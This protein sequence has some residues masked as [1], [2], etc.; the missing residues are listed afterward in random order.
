MGLRA[1]APRLS[2]A[3]I[4]LGLALPLDQAKLDGCAAWL[5]R[6]LVRAFEAEPAVVLAVPEQLGLG[7]TITLAALVGGALVIGLGR[8]HT[9]LSPPIAARRLEPSPLIE[10][11]V[12]MI[13]VALASSLA[14][15]VV[16]AAA[17]SVDASPTALV[18]VWLIW[19]RRALLSVGAC[20]LMIGACEWLVSA[21]ALWRALHVTDEQARELAKQLGPR[22]R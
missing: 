13:G 22:R 18:S 20:A 9:P 4:A 15:P 11:L 8:T 17:R 5:D 2:L 21:R 19:L 6:Q 3:A 12:L 1:R 16:A 10:A 7:V 14:L